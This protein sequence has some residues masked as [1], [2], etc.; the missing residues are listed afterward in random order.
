MTRRLHAGMATKRFFESVL[1]LWVGACAVAV[2]GPLALWIPSL[3]PPW[4]EGSAA[5]VAVVFSVIA[6]VLGYAGLTPLRG[7][8]AENERMAQRGLWIGCLS[9]V[10]SMLLCVLYFY[11]YSLYVVKDVKLE[12]RSEV[13][14]RR[15]IGTELLDSRDLKRPPTELLKE[16]S[17]EEERIWTRSSLTQGRLLVLFSYTGMFF[18]LCLGLGS[19]GRR[20]AGM[21]DRDPVNPDRPGP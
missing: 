5:I 8:A 6:L 18:F 17:F 16:N 10:A 14:I 2:G 13:T 7:S 19:L 12:G 9:L 20:F 4:P 1:A 15:V 3:E 21:P 11:A